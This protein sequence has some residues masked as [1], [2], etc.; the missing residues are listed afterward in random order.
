MEM[1]HDADRT[2]PT[3][4]TI[5]AELKLAIA[6]HLD[7]DV[8]LDLRWSGVAQHDAQTRRSAIRA[9]S[10]VSR[11]WAA[12]LEDLRWQVRRTLLLRRS[13]SSVW[14]RLNHSHI[15]QTLRLRAADTER[16][17][18]LA[19]DYM[20]R[21]GPK[22]KTL[23]LTWWTDADLR[24]LPRERDKFEV[25]QALAAAGRFTCLESASPPTLPELCALH[26]ALIA[27]ILQACSDLLSL[28]VL[29]HTNAVLK[30]VD[31]EGAEVEFYPWTTQ[32]ALQ[33]IGG[34]NHSGRTI[35]RRLKFQFLSS[36]DSPAEPVAKHQAPP[37]SHPRRVFRPRYAGFVCEDI[38]TAKPCQLGS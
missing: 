33:G 27:T 8:P 31:P 26:D 16:L 30:L 32:A 29:Q 17:L 35:P 11:S 38:R 13:D 23:V 15:W 18:E 19:R 10:L 24:E 5:P 4:E 12:A 20:P 36:S 9:L 7:P 22:V 6:D 14:S 25:Q 2:V 37:Y 1:M 34:K 21:C 3:L 28:T